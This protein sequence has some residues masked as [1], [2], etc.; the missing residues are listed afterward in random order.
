MKIFKWLFL[1][2]SLSVM[3]V[4]GYSYA[5]EKKQNKLQI[6]MQNLLQDTQYLVQGMML[7]DYTL[8]AESADRIADHPTPGL[9]VQMKLLSNMGGDL[10]AFKTLDDF[11]HDRAVALREAGQS[12][13][14]ERVN[15]EF[16]ALLD[17]CQSC[18]SRFKAKVHNILSK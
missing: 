10:S 3:A 7:E 15:T 8:I 2:I 9:A 5:E 11:V 13:D 18:H 12:K 6:V 4:G 1:I 16:T 17:G 14:M